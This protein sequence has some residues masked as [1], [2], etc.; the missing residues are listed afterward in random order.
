M[1]SKILETNRKEYVSNNIDNTSQ[2]F[3]VLL[4]ALPFESDFAEMKRAMQV[5]QFLFEKQSPL[6]N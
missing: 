3:K 2:P 6:I 1:A 4:S 5:V